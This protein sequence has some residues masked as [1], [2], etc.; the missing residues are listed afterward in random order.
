M[1]KI[2]L[3][4]RDCAGVNAAIRA[5]V[6]T[7][8]FHN[9][10]V[11]GIFHGY[12]GLINGEVKLFDRRSVSGIINLGGTILKTSRSIK[13]RTE[14]GRN[15][16]L[17]TIKDNNLDGLIV[18]GGNGSLSGAYVLSEKCSIP[19]IGIPATIDNDVYGVDMT[20]GADTAVNVALDALDKI[21]DT[22]TSL[23]RIFIVE[24]MG[25]ECGYI[26]LN[27]ALA[28][29][30]EEVLIPEADYNIEKICEEITEGNIRGKISWIIIVAEGKAKA[31]DIAK[32]VTDITSLQTR[33][34]VLGHIQRGGRPTA[35]DRILAARYGSFAV[36][37]MKKGEKNKYVGLN[38]DKLI[39]LPL[40]NIVKP[41]DIKVNDYYKLIKILT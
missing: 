12:E 18:I 19:I 7:A 17:K 22:S 9:I 30:C 21:R 28:G 1:K 31:A 6:R 3:L 37:L 2:G 40:K 24:V 25:R 41:K 33:E 15:M 38:N 34:V 13:F 27:V 23:E 26:A 29:G 11:V 10:E 14:E 35:F 20:I 5:V 4:T 39:T 8:A 16:A 32:Q 36:E